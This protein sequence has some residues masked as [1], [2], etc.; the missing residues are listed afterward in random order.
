MTAQKFTLPHNVSKKHRIDLRLSHINCMNASDTD[1]VPN[2]EGNNLSII[3]S[4]TEMSFAEAVNQLEDIQSKMRWLGRAET[5]YRRLLED[6]DNQ[7]EE[8]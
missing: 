4:D 1:G 6:W 8:V 2:V 3:I 5:F 7:T